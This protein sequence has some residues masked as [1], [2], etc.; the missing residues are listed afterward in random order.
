MKKLFPIEIQENTIQSYFVKK[1]TTSKV[2]YWIILFIIIVFFSLLPFIYVDITSQSRG[3]M[4]SVNENNSIQSAL[5]SEVTKIDL[6]ENKHVEAGDTLIWLRTDEL[7]EQLLRS[8]QRIQE[9]EAFIVDLSNLVRGRLIA[10]TPKYRTELAEY[11]AILAE[12]RL[13]LD[14]IQKEYTISKTLFDKKLESEFNHQQIENRLL[15]EKSQLNLISEQYRNRW[16]AERTRL[17][18]DNDNIKSEIQ[19]N[20]NRQSQYVITA[21]ISGNI[22]QFIGLQ[23]GNFLSPG[24]TIAQI[25]SVDSLLLECFVAPSDIGY[26]RLGQSVKLQADAF[27]YQQWGLLNGEV[28]EVISDVVHVENQPFF[29]V[30]CALE[31]DYLELDNGYK[32]V[33]KKGMTGTT[34]F[35]LTRRSLGQLLFDKINNWMNPKIMNNEH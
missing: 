20:K 26:I 21:P 32:G 28:V 7:N 22:V 5:Y 2:I 15:T 11:K 4:R 3:V 23:E 9:N 33:L 18:Q 17:K 19:Q 31:R 24:Q 27:N 14:K 25:S 1:Y 13:N 12:K 34:R 8:G 6:Y 35:F 30:R 29:R 10:N 16:E